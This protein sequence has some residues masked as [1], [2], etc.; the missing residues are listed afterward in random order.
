MNTA[1]EVVVITLAGVVG[2]GFFGVPVLRAWRARGW[3]TSDGE[4]ET[5][6]VLDSG[7]KSSRYRVEV[8]YRYRVGTQELRSRRVSFF[9]VTMLHGSRDAAQAHRREY[10]PRTGITV[11][12]KPDDPQQAVIDTGVPW[13]S[14]LAVA[15]C[16][17]FVIGG[18]V[19]LVRF[20]I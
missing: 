16:A 9:S 6:D 18:V 15:F 3:P 1:K 13:T 14:Y 19:G 20:V 5:S 8:S 10:A 12:Y 17:L 4:V 7:S 11:R 2:L